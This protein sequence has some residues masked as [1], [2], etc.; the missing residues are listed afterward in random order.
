MEI[1]SLSVN[2][3]K[4]ETMHDRGCKVIMFTPELPPHDMTLLFGF[5]WVQSFCCIGENPINEMPDNLWEALIQK[6]KEWK[7]I[8]QRLRNALYVLWEQDHC[9]INNFNDFYEDRM[10]KLIN[11]VMEKIL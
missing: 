4:I 5:S 7:S 1:L 10:Q 9:K 8:S 11:Q 6:P 2:I 3:T